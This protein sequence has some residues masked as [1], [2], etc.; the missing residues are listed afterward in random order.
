[1]RNGDLAEFSEMLDA[2]CSLISR[3]TY[4]PNGA[5]TA[6][7]FRA[8]AKHDFTTVRA[9]FDAH[10]KDTQRG[11]WVPT[12]ADILAQIEGTDADDGR[13]GPEEAWAIAL[14]TVD[15]QR[16]VVWTPEIAEAWG[17][18]RTVYAQGDEVGGRMAFKEA[19]TRIVGNARSSGVR[20]TW[21]PS[22]GIDPKQRDAAL[23]Q[24]HTAGLLP[25][26][27]PLVQLPAPDHALS[28]ANTAMPAQVRERL[29]ELRERLAG[30]VAATTPAAAGDEP[31]MAR[32]T[33]VPKQLQ[34]W[35][36]AGESD[37]NVPVEAYAEEARQP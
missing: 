32:F 14:T 15:E 31:P 25:R 16:T 18:A 30:R 10:V 27:E 36:K 17:I 29:L 7:W 26:P 4:T 19:Y 23:M 24:A 33:P 13:P 22:L 9:A 34:P 21:M 8:L 11:R 3:G 35:V 28:P 37:G 12:P 1:M 20:P 5:N 2:V 6:L